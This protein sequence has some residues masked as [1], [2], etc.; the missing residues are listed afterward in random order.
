[1]EREKLM[2]SLSIEK[3]IYRESFKGFEYWIIRPFCTDFSQTP[4]EY[5]PIHLCGYIVIPKNSKYYISNEADDYNIECH[6]GLSFANSIS[7][8]SIPFCIGFDCA[9]SCDISRVD[10]DLIYGKYRNVNYVRWEC[11]NII[12]Q[13]LEND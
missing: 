1:M 12:N 13:L 10:E 9:H 8:L 11:K 4:I 2:E 6:G 3:N 5:N 7:N